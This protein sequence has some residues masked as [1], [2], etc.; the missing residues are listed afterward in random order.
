MSNPSLSPPARGAYR[1]TAFVALAAAALLAGPAAAQ[2]ESGRELLN[3]ERIEQAFGSYGIEVLAH[4]DEVRVSNLY[5][6]TEDARIT[7]TFAVVLY[8]APEDVEAAYAAEHAEIVA[9]GSIGA[10]F[11]DNGWNVRKRHRF[12]GR[13][14]ST[15]RLERMMGDIAS[16]PLATHVYGLRVADAGDEYAY[17]TIV[18]IHHPDY[19]TLEDL[20]RIYGD[21]YD[22]P[23]TLD[24]L[25]ALT[26]ALQAAAARIE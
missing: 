1:C 15:P 20:R 18:E 8:P 5:S 21:G 4:G 17:A 25:T 2:P 9:G 12:F 3:S 6:R 19:L 24:G 11:K 10:V 7:R 13:L 14:D 26:G 22:P 23:V 16:Q